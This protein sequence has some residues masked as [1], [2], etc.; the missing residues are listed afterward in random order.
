MEGAILMPGTKTRLFLPALLLILLV[1]L[2]GCGGASDPAA[3]AADDKPDS[4]RIA[5]DPASPDQKPPVLTLTANSAL[6]LQLYATTFALPLMPQNVVCTLERGPHYTL[7]FLRN[8][9][10]LATA[11][12]KRDGCHPVTITGEKQDRQATS[13]FWSQLDQAIQRATPATSGQ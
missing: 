5:T 7:T 1:L 3:S 12:A 6:V 4:V 9:K 2:S 13:A 10:P 11:L 8:N